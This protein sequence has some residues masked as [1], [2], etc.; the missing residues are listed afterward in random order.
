MYLL[1]K[2]FARF[3]LIRVFLKILLNYANP[4][5]CEKITFTANSCSAVTM[6]P[7]A[8]ANLPIQCGVMCKA[9]QAN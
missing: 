8:A 2:S 4:D 9:T 5:E 6:N 7:H 1:P 3:T